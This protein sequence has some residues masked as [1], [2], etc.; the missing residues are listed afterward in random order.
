MSVP[1]QVD[2]K[3]Y[4]VKCHFIYILKS[5]FPLKYT[6]CFRESLPYLLFGVI[7]DSIIARITVFNVLNVS[8][9]DYSRFLSSIKVETKTLAF[10]TVI[11]YYLML[12]S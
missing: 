10:I 7:R 8:E 11:L 6:G 2:D 12:F 9:F 1:A 4:T 3:S 5:S